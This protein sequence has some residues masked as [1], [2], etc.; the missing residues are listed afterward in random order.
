MDE[1][2]D[3]E[4]VLVVDD[5][6]DTLRMLTDVLDAAGYT[7]LVATSATRALVLV[8]ETAPALILMDAMMPEI[9]GF[10]MTRRLKSDMATRDIPV[11][12]MTG[13]TDAADMIRG[14]EAGGVD[15]VTKP[16]V[17]PT[18]LA[19]V[20]A[21]LATAR[22]AEARADLLDASGRYV[23]AVDAAGAIVW[24]SQ[25]A[26]AL[27]SGRHGSNEQ[28]N[29][30]LAHGFMDWLAA[31]P[32]RV[33]AGKPAPARVDPALAVRFE[34][35]GRSRSGEYLLRVMQTENPDGTTGSD[36]LRARFAL[37]PREAEVLLWI[38]RG[39]SNKDIADILG[40]SPRTVN[41]HLE[42]VFAKM[43][44]ENRSAAAALAVA[45]LLD[46]R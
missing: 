19:R 11:I 34:Y 1:E 39:K 45:A 9:D 12:F 27:L 5:S 21:H 13:L 20:R 29:P 15:Y 43:G 16:V 46:T 23:L 3:T 14:F 22:Q 32:E 2:P 25:K 33:Q 44:V 6:L 35:L 38:G 28:G 18:L 7:V 26:S 40:M 37:T 10:E 41:K 8:R 36:I 24:A 42:T 17:V 31:L 4:T 30:V